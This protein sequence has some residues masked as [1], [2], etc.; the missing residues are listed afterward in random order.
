MAGAGFK[1]FVD[2]DIFTASEA[3]TYLMQQTVMVFATT[4]ARDSAI[5][6]PSEGMFAFTKDADK[7][8][9][10][11]GSSWVETSLAA[12]IT[13]VTAGSGLAGG[14]SSGTVTLSLDVDAKG[15]LLVG[16]TADTVAKVTVGGNNTILTADS[17][18]ASGVKWTST[19]TSPTIVTPDVTG[20]VVD[21]LQEDW[22]VS[23]TAATGTVNL[24]VKTASAWYYTSNA[25]ANWT[26]NIRGD[27]STTLSSLLAV[28]DSITITFAVTNGATPYYQTAFQI[29]G[30]SVTPKWQG[31]SAPAAGNA[32]SIDVYTF[33]IIK[34]A[35]TPT[36]TVLGSVTR[37]A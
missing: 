35:A 2:G 4:T 5:T 16:T 28:G 14:G 30:N 1:T 29:D 31:G 27:G 33:S 23:A 15:D 37:F 12:D 3:N 26:L 6:A 32:S 22:N 7:L 13:G 36:Y 11:D 8:W 17:A 20:G 10:Y 21:Q 9:Y 24:D 25:S 18:Q 34:T 19:I